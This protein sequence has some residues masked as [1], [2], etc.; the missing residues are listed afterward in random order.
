M[1]SV[2]GK[3]TGRYRSRSWLSCGDDSIQARDECDDGVQIRAGQSHRKR[4]HHRAGNA[5]IDDII[6]ICLIE[7][8]PGEPRRAAATA[9]ISGMAVTGTGLVEDF[10]A[11]FDGILSEGGNTE[12]QSGHYTENSA[13][14]AG[15]HQLTLM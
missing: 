12:T 1:R 10:L 6:Y 3:R 14:G 11:A 15:N 7:A 4:R 13:F 9:A 8:A 5:T 2:W